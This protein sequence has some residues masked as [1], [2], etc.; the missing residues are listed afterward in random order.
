MKLNGHEENVLRNALNPKAIVKALV[1]LVTVRNLPYN[2]S[3]WPELHALLMA[4]N[5]IAE[6]AISLSHS[7][8]QKLV[9]NSYFIHK[10][11]LQK[12]LQSSLSE[13]YLSADIWTTPNHKAFLRTCVQ[14]VENN[15]KET[16]QALLALSEPPGLDGPGSHSRAE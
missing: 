4:V 10:D 9:F 13:L 12:K 16:R 15:K 2:Y 11:I 5:Y 14:F 1:Q 3:Q 8:V 7:A 6:N